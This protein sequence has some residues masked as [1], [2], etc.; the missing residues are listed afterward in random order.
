MSFRR[1]EWVPK[2]VTDPEENQQCLPRITPTYRKRPGPRNPL[3]SE[4][5]EFAGGGESCFSKMQK[6]LMSVEDSPNRC[7]VHADHELEKLTR[8]LGNLIK[9]HLSISSNF[10]DFP[11]LSLCHKLWPV[12]VT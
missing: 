11:T 12:T 6:T 4:Q 5:K 3:C 9:K 7:E 10:T 1:L 8:I 2:G